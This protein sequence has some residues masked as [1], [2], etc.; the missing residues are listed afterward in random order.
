MKTTTVRFLAAAVALAANVAFAA[1]EGDMAPNDKAS[2]QLYWQGQA[3]L[4]KDGFQL[5][6]P[7]KVTGSGVPSSLQNLVSG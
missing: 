5:V 6:V 1:S 2:N 7:A 4:K 3:A